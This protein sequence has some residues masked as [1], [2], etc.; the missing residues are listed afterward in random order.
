MTQ[1]TGLINAFLLDGKGGGK[2]LN[3]EEI[4]AWTPN[5]SVLW[6]HLNFTSE[7]A[8]QWLCN[9]SG[10]DPL[11]AEALNRLQSERVSWLS[12][13]DRLQ[14]REAYDQ[15]TRYLEELDSAR[16]RAGVAYQGLSSRIAEQMNTRMYVLSL[17]AGLFLP[18]GFLTGLL[19]INVGGIP[20]ADSLWG[21]FEV[22]VFLLI[23]VLV[24]IVIFRR[25][26]WF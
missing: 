6:V 2:P 7:S 22:V 16:D 5:R 20:L 24:Q 15:S 4:R 23:L 26:H 1:D 18:L 12:E 3:W 13:H 19:G 11:M 9:E 17:I 14:V 10:L 8:Q 21:F 25:K